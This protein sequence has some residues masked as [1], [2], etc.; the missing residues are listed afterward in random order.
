M[1]ERN[2]TQ[3]STT[4]LRDM[5][6]HLTYLKLAFIAAQYAELATQAAQKEWS[7]VDYLA[8]LLEGEADLRRDRATK[9]RLRLARFPVIKTVEQFR[10]DWP[11]RIN[12][13]QVQHHFHLKFIQDK[14]NLIFLGGVGLGKTH[15]A[16]ALGYA[17]CLQGYSVLFVSA[18]EVINTLAAAR[19]AG[20][21]KSELKKY[22]KPALLIL[23]E[24]GY[25]PIDKAGAD[26][27]FQVISLRYEQGAIIVTSNRAFKEWPKIF[28]N[29]STLPSAILDRLLHHA[30]TIIIEGKS[31]RMKDQLES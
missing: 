13:L 22:T 12:R 4:P 15:L 20:R 14:S 29:D 27:L 3:E 7:H 16:T 24:L 19:S 21:L 10:W 11:T 25:L 30:D 28:N 2:H 9:S 23:D 31:F 18:I 5:E 6:H 8:R 17:A 1:S 26:L